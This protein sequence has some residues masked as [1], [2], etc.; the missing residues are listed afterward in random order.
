MPVC[1]Q[2]P[3]KAFAMPPMCSRPEECGNVRF[4][5]HDSS[6]LSQDCVCLLMLAFS[7]QLC[8]VKLSQTQWWS[9]PQTTE[10]PRAS[11][12]FKDPP[13]A[14]NEVENVLCVKEEQL[15]MDLSVD[16]PCRLCCR[17]WL[18]TILPIPMCCISQTGCQPWRLLWEASPMV[19]YHWMA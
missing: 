5:L 15:E 19:I 9:V 8:L 18:T 13:T 12:G 16:Q 2:L 14:Q 7:P 1:S 10:V 4:F 17:Y 3:M 6:L 11:V